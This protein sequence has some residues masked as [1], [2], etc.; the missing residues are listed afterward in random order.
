MASEKKWNQLNILQIFSISFILI[1]F[2]LVSLL[3]IFE[4]STNPM[5]IPENYIYNYL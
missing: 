2:Y 4:T 5:K 1:F 3:N